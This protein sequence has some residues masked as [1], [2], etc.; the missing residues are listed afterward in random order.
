VKTS[1]LRTVPDTPTGAAVI[2]VDAAGQNCIVVS[3]GANASL[4]LVDLQ[5]A[6]SSIADAGM[7]VAQLE[8]PL[9]TVVELAAI[10][11][12]VGTFMM[13]DPAPVPNEGLPPEL[14]D[15]DLLTP[16]RTEAL[17]LAGHAVTDIVDPEI[18]AW[19][20]LERGARAVALK[21]DKD[22]ALVA[23]RDGMRLI[24]PFKANVVDTTAA[25]DAFT[26]ALAVMLTT[27]ASLDEAACFANAA[28]AVACEKVGAIASL[29]TLDLVEERL[30]A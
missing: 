19:Q 4:S 25:G 14:F 10:C 15:V 29:P 12:R 13:L 2:L 21:L 28:G 24:P 16:N 8:I 5:A 6:E 22:G 20:L 7:V 17:L 3:P 9:K 18:L 23:N 26:A 27:G 30:T 11:R 1:L